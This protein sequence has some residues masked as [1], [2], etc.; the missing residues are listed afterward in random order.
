VVL[1]NILVLSVLGG[2]FFG[3]GDSETSSETTSSGSGITSSS[4]ETTLEKPSEA[5]ETSSSVVA[6]KSTKN[7]KYWGEWKSLESSEEVYITTKSD[8]KIVE[9][10]NNLISINGENYERV[11]F[12]NVKIDGSFKE[13]VTKA[14]KSSP[15]SSIGSIEIILEN[16]KDSNI[17]TKIDVEDDGTFEDDSMPTG[18]YKM[19]LE[20]ENISI[21]TL[22]Q[23]A[24][25]YEKLQLN[26]DANQKTLSVEDIQN[27]F[28]GIDKI[29]PTAKLKVT[30]NE[31]YTSFD[32]SESSDD[33]EI[34]S[35]I[36]E[37]SIDGRIYKGTRNYFGSSDLTSGEHIFTL[38]IYD[39]DGLQDEAKETEYIEYVDD[40]A[41]EDGYILIDGECVYVDDTIYDTLPLPAF[42]G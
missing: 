20:S 40:P 34:I 4:L 30:T 41:C 32:F 14:I 15:Y 38:T 7:S 35:Y 22:I 33:G 36:L 25:E 19:N 23:F 18:E 11:G 39:D 13:Q 9:I 1:K 24:N 27:I 26:L 16:L 5:T 2:S 31:G 12:R 3:C 29:K 17:E 28:A 37:S 6:E 8:F 42:P 10:G 21:S